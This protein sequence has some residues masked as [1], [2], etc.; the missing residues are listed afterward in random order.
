MKKS[1]YYTHMR[2]FAAAGALTAQFIA[3]LLTSPLMSLVCFVLICCTIAADYKYA[4]ALDDEAEAEYEAHL[5]ELEHLYDTQLHRWQE[6]DS[7][8]GMD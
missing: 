5:K 8:A 4:K 3:M 2:T 7:Y 1:D 6:F